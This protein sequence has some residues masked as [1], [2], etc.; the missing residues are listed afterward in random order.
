MT[1]LDAGTRYPVASAISLVLLAELGRPAG[2]PGRRTPGLRRRRRPRRRRGCW[3]PWWSGHVTLPDT[4]RDSSTQLM[5]RGAA[6]HRLHRLVLDRRRLLG[7]GAGAGV[8]AVRLAP[9]WP[10]MGSRYDAPGRREPTTGAE[11]PEPERDL[12][13]ALDEGRDPTDTSRTSA[14]RATQARRAP[15][16]APTY[17]DAD[18]PEELHVRQPRQHPRCLDGR[19]R[20]PRRFVVGGI[21]LMVGSWLVF[22]I[23]VALAPSALVALLVM[24]KMGY[25]DQQPLR[26]H[27]R[28]CRAPLRRRH[29][30]LRLRDTG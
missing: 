11:Q 25:C 26:R 16:T 22:W 27:G 8:L 18:R 6:G 4:A 2:H 1:A 7:A 15:E 10:E 3:P 28:S 21:G 12:W 30:A 5:G 19:G 13:H 23:G 14:R 20:G 9:A 24:A 29:A 17:A